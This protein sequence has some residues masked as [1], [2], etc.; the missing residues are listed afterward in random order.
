MR[1]IAFL[2]Q[3]A[4][5]AVGA[6]AALEFRYYGPETPQFWVGVFATP[7]EFF[8]ALVGVLLW[9]RGPRVRRLVMLAGLIMA[10][11]TIFA[12]ALGVM[13]RPATLVGIASAL[14]ALA[15]SWKTGALAPKT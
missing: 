5:F 4:G 11:A 12:T 7:A 13:G 8:F 9:L 10:A 2:M 3:L 14:T 1:I 15:W 6:G